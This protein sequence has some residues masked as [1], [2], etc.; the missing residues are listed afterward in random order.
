MSGSMVG[1]KPDLYI[2]VRGVDQLPEGNSVRLASGFQFYVTHVLTGAFQH[3][4]GV[5]QVRAVEEA[6]VGVAL[7]D[8]DVSERR[9]L[10]A[11]YGVPVVH[12]LQDVF[13]ACTDSPEPGARHCGQRIRLVQPL[14]DDGVTLPRAGQSEHIVHRHGHRF[15]SCRY[16]RC[17]SNRPK[18][19]Q[20]AAGAYLTAPAH[21]NAASV[22]LSLPG[23]TAKPRSSAPIPGSRCDRRERS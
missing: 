1:P 19:C 7:E 13:A 3:P 20:S 14:L 6:D 23:T 17:Y 4:D 18:S 16:P 11:R 8:I 10:Y 22:V 9:V 15:R 21:P 5:V 2:Q 12:Q